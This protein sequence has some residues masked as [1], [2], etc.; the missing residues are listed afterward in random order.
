VDW[1]YKLFYVVQILALHL[2]R[3]VTSKNQ[4]PQVS[5]VSIQWNHL[6]MYVKLTGIKICMLLVYAD[7]TSL[8]FTKPELVSSI[9][10]FMRE[11]TGSLTSSS[12]SHHSKYFVRAGVS[13]S[14]VYVS[15]GQEYSIRVTRVEMAHSYV[16][17]HLHT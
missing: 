7:F 6:A 8:G 1:A 14:M 9:A 15:Q 5:H 17:S 4:F 10:F 3:C 2:V 11:R 16:H 12:D 13:E